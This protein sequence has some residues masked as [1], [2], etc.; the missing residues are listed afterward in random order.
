MAYQI[1]TEAD[2]EKLRLLLKGNKNFEQCA[3]AFEGRSAKAIQQYAMRHGLG[4]A[5]PYEWP[6]REIEILKQI[7][8][9]PRAIKENMHLLPRRSYASATAM[10]RRIG[11]AGKGKP[12]R[13][14]TSLVFKICIPILRELGPLTADE[15][16][17]KT[18]QNAQ[19]IREAMRRNQGRDSR[20]AGWKRTTP[21]H[22]AAQWGLGSDPDA[23]RPRALTKSEQNRAYSKRLKA[24]RANPFLVAAGEVK[25]I[26]TLHGRKFEQDMTI[27][28]DHLDE[29][30]AA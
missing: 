2:I 26:E 1:W 23:P 4:K 20:I 21:F 14:S 18:G 15:L 11:L 28:L 9:S 13:G 30:E 24:R 5:A 10:A 16:A 29:M 3:A 6:D 22:W 12:A 19:T 8:S 7:Y 27:H 17:L 25:P